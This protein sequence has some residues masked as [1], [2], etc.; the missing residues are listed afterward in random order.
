MVKWIWRMLT[1]NTQSM[2]V[3]TLHIKGFFFLTNLVFV[4]LYL[5]RDIWLWNLECY[6]YSKKCCYG[7]HFLVPGF[8]NT[9]CCR[10]WWWWAAGRWKGMF[11]TLM[12]AFFLVARNSNLT[13]I[14]Q[15]PAYLC[16]S[17]CI[18]VVKIRQMGANLHSSAVIT[19][20]D[21]PNSRL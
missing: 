9:E 5:C 3:L 10:W 8:T 7:V 14:S 11:P 18:T 19:N 12:R 16:T 6:F 21:K 13:F 1:N 2:K 17:Q 15:L 4:F 20:P